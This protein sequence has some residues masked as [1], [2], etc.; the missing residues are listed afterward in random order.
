MRIKICGLTQAEQCQAVAR[1]GVHALGFIC[2]PSSPRFVPPDRLF[3]LLQELPPFLTRVGVFADSPL[4]EIVQQVRATGLNA[5]QLHGQ[6]SPE[7]CREL[8][9]AL[10]GVEIIRAIR[11]Q[12]PDQ[13]VTLIPYWPHI[14]AVLLDAYQPGQLGGTGQPLAWSTLV[15]FQPP[16]PW[17]LAGGLT[18]ENISTALTTLNPAGIDVSSGVESDPGIKD[19]TRVRHLLEVIHQLK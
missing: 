12:S 14:S 5:V 1:L 19:L 11:L 7:D 2:V 9:Q 13:L 4:I 18:P 3:E 6:E 16:K 17:V 8:C 15:H 10:P